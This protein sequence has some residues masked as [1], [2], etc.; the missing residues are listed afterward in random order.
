[1]G[2]DEEE[3]EDDDDDRIDGDDETVFKHKVEQL[4]PKSE[5]FLQMLND[6]RRR[7]RDLPEDSPAEEQYR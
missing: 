4:K 6:M 7:S 5:I 3:D 1:M 2:R